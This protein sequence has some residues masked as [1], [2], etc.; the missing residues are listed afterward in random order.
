MTPDVFNVEL[1]AAVDELDDGSYTFPLSGSSFNVTAD[2]EA[3]TAT[4]S[5]TPE[6][7]LALDGAR[8]R[9]LKY[10]LRNYLDRDDTAHA[11]LSVDGSTVNLEIPAANGP[12]VDAWADAAVQIIDRTLYLSKDE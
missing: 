9:L 10:Q 4:L 8:E 6:E 11:D 3:E 12:A 7:P 5:F 1:D 2:A